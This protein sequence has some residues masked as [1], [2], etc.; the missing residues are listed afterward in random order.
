MS[1]GKHCNRQNTVVGDPRWRSMGLNV[2]HVD[3]KVNAISCTSQQPIPRSVESVLQFTPWH[4]GRFVHSSPSSISLRE[5]LRLILIRLSS[6]FTL[7]I[8]L[9]TCKVLCPIIVVHYFNHDTMKKHTNS[10]SYIHCQTIFNQLS[11]PKQKVTRATYN[12]N[13]CVFS[14]PAGEA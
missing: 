6:K 3:I 11:L 4:C 9:S 10:I 5:A 2:D 12:N 13:T 1:H 7:L 8:H 14:S